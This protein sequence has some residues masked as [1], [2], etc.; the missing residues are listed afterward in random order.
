MARHYSEDGIIYDMDYVT[1]WLRFEHVQCADIHGEK[2]WAE[3]EVTRV[4]KEVLESIAPLQTVLEAAIDRRD[5]AR[6]ADDYAGI[7]AAR[8]ALSKATRAYKKA[9]DA[10]TDKYTLKSCENGDCFAKGLWTHID[11]D[12][13]LLCNKCTAE[14]ER[15]VPPFVDDDPE[16]E[17]HLEEEEPV[18]QYNKAKLMMELVKLTAKRRGID[19][20]V[21]GFGGD[22]EPVDDRNGD[23]WSFSVSIRKHPKEK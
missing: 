8:K 15:E 7:D 3:K 14:D 19:I 10:A 21:S 4:A 5:V 23:C 1:H 6:Q 17:E 12:G 9:Y 11:K 16:Q 22:V 2:P 18:K 13:Y 20:D